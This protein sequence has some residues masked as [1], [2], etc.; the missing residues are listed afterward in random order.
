MI[1][2]RPMIRGLMQAGSAVSASLFQSTLVD[3][4]FPSSELLGSNKVRGPY[5]SSRENAGFNGGTEAFRGVFVGPRSR[6]VLGGVMG[7]WK[8]PM[9]MVRKVAG[10]LPG[11]IQ[12]SARLVICCI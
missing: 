11:G 12:A 2:L 9:E 3:D 6:E 7:A 5:R 1:A 10:D 8:P 4:T